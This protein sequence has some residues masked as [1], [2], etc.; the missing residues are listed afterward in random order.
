MSASLREGHG[1]SVDVDDAV[2]PRVVCLLDTTR[3]STIFRGVTTVHVN[4]VQCEPARTRAHVC[5]EV[6]KRIPPRAHGNTSATIVF[7]LD[8]IGVCAAPLHGRPDPVLGSAG[9]P[10]RR[11]I[12]LGGLAPVTPTTHDQSAPEGIQ[13]SSVRSPAVTCTPPVAV[14][15]VSAFA[16]L[17]HEAAKSL[18]TNIVRSSHG[19]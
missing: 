14:L 9:H 7:P 5:V 4:P 19:L 1:C 17:R 16:F 3:P 11:G 6:I 8:D 13:R 12:S 2:G 15:R 18:P 10:V